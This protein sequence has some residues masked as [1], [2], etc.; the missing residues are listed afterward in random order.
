MCNLH[1]DEVTSTLLVPIMLFSPDRLNVKDTDLVQRLQDK[2]ATLLRKYMNWRYGVEQ[3]DI[4]YPKLL[5]QIVN[6]RALGLAHGEIIQKFMA[7]SSV[8]PLVQEVITKPDMLTK[9]PPERTGKENPIMSTSIESISSFVDSVSFTSSPSPDVEMMDFDKTPSNDTES[10]MGSDEDDFAR[11]KQRSPLDDDFDFDNDNIGSDPRTIWRKRP[12][13]SNNNQTS[14]M[15]QT[16]ITKMDERNPRSNQMKTT[17]TYK[18]VDKYPKTNGLY[19]R[20]YDH[21]VPTVIPAQRDD[22]MVMSSR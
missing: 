15:M 4:V 3:T 5:L 2:Y 20:P 21:Q 1:I 10:N 18:N 13:F 11:K 17:D 12:K 16:E 9:L 22:L 8:N 7:S 14:S 6:I 19:I